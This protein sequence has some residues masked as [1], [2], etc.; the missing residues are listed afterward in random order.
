VQNPSTYPDCG[1]Y[2]G[3]LYTRRRTVVVT[4]GAAPAAA[5]PAAG[6]SQTRW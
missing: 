3:D 6:G 1:R 2:L 4:Q 5:A